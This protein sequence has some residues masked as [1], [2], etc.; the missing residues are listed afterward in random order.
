MSANSCSAQLDTP[1]G[2]TS[3]WLCPHPDWSPA[4]GGPPA[5]LN[6]G[7]PGTHVSGATKVAAACHSVLWFL[8]HWHLWSV[9]RERKKTT[10]QDDLSR[11]CCCC[12]C[13]ATSSVCPESQVTACPHP[14]DC[15]LYWHC[16]ADKHKGR[17][18]DLRGPATRD[19]ATWQH[20]PPC[21]DSC[22]AVVK[23]QLDSLKVHLA[24]IKQKQNWGSYNTCKIKWH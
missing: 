8:F 11:C 2:S 19:A 17:W 9:A 15:E 10:K 16:V 21:E 24:F 23:G 13:S 4:H 6:T 18:T 7:A 3:G 20:K 5:Y 1:A 14:D 22:R 12:C